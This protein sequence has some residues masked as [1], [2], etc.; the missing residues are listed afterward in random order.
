[1]EHFTWFGWISNSINHHNIHILSGALVV[2]II[3]LLSFLYK[4]SLQSVDKEVVPT[5]KFSLKNMV[6]VSVEG[7]LSMAEG[8]IGKDA[9]LYFPLIAAVFIYIFLNNMLGL[10]P[11]FL[12]AT[13]SPSTNFA[14]AL[15]VFL[16]Y[17]FVGIKKQGFV[18]YFKHFMG[19]IWWLAPLM[20]VIE[21]VSHFIR[22]VTLSVRL[23][24]NISGDHIVLGIFSELVPIVVPVIFMAF[25]IFVA[26][27]Q[28]FV[29]TLLSTVY[30][31]FATAEEEH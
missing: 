3:V 9:I 7:I 25:G 28:A 18:H 23:L 6:Q 1:M 10:I 16:Y 31:S 2:L 20:L 13:E 14:V 19:P 11:G 30:I 8:I 15:T 21:L 22:P 4:R 26:F 12:P 29:F 17:N 27:V 24:A 5:S